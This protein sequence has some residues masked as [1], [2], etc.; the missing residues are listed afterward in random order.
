MYDSP[1]PI[2]PEA[3]KRQKNS[4]GP[5]QDHDR[6]GWRGRA[7]QVLCGTAAEEMAVWELDCYWQLRHGSGEQGPGSGRAERGAFGHGDVG[8]P[9]GIDGAVRSVPRAGGH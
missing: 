1:N 2:R 4:R 7:A 6:R 9:S 8:P 3:P 5:V